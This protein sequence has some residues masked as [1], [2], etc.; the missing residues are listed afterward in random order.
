M[1][2]LDVKSLCPINFTVEIFGDPWSL[3]IVREIAAFGKRTFG[4]LM[5]TQ[6][7][8]GSSVLADRLAHLER[9]DIIAHESDSSDKRKI[10][11]GLT[12]RGLSTLPIL[13]EVAVWGSRTS[14]NPVSAP[15]WFTSLELDRATVLAAWHRAL[16]SDSSFFSGPNSVVV[17][18]KL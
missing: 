7:R 15:E 13:Y 10:L 6:E 8:I 14:L 17:Q 9:A 11:Y 1:K 12:K 18:L 16:E 4:Q 3:L 5:S 2:R